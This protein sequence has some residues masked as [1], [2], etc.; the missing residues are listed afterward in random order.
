MKR[1]VSAISLILLTLVVKAQ[2]IDAF[3][4]V[5]P[6]TDSRVKKS[7]NGEWQ[8]KVVKG[9]SDETTVPAADETWGHIPVPGCWEAYGF[10]TPSYDKAR[11]LTGYYRTAFTVPD[12]WKGQR[13]IIRFDGVL[14]G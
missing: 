9:I 14:Y 4:G 2:V 10:C 1:I 5:L 12:A 6:V 13:I 8:L 7:L 11:A 3:S